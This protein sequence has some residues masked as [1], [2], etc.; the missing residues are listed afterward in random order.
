MVLSLYGIHGLNRALRN[1]RSVSTPGGH[2]GP[3][4]QYVRWGVLQLEEQG[5]DAGAEEEAVNE[6]PEEHARAAAEVIVEGGAEEVTG[7]V[8]DEEQCGQI[9]D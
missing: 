7:G 1:L 5:P 9:E 3:P 2:G 8:R 4:L 6:S